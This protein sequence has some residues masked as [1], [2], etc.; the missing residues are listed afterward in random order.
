[1]VIADSLRT[2][3]PGPSVV[4]GEKECGIRHTGGISATDDATS[5]IPQAGK[6]QSLDGTHPELLRPAGTDKSEDCRNRPIERQQE[7]PGFARDFPDLSTLTVENG[8]QEP[9]FDRT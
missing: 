9:S 3:A 5:S 1:M 7:I 6:E 4:R 2:G 8:E